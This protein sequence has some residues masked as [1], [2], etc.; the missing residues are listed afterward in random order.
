MSKIMHY[1]KNV[2]G[3]NAY[4]NQA[5]DDLKAIIHQKGPPTIF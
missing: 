5:R 2:T 1:S 4:W 3:T